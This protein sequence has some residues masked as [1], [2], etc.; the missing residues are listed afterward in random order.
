MA[1][2][3]KGQTIDLLIKVADRVW[4]A[5]LKFGPVD[6]GRPEGEEFSDALDH[7]RGISREIAYMQNT[8][9][10]TRKAIRA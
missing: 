2:R 9:G 1:R 8:R 5:Y 4:K 7:L 6:D 10:H 3:T